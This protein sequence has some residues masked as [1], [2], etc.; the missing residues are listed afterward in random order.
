M[1]FKIYVYV[2]GV[3]VYVGDVR[4]RVYLHIYKICELG[5]AE[6]TTEYKSETMKM[7]EKKK[8]MTSGTTVYKA[9]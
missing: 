2:G 5:A 8:M 9:E 7:L 1:W 3:R 6:W 4:V